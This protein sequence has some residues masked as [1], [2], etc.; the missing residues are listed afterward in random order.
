MM[1]SALL[2]LDSL[3]YCLHTHTTIVQQKERTRYGTVDS[4]TVVYIN[5]LG[6]DG[7][8][9]PYVIYIAICILMHQQTAYDVMTTYLTTTDHSEP[10]GKLLKLK[11]FFRNPINRRPDSLKFCP[12]VHRDDRPKP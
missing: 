6:V 2:H 3:T 8:E 9:A 1:R 11:H 4:D 10:I 5:T 7:V 12:G